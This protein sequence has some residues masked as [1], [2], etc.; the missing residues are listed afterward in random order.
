VGGEEVLV[1]YDIRPVTVPERLGTPEAVEFEASAA[2]GIQL[3]RA[4]WGHGDF[5]D[6]ATQMLARR[7]NDTHRGYA[8]FGAWEGETM[9]GRASLGWEREADASTVELTLGVLPSHRRR[10][11]G[12]RLLAAAE[13]AARDHGKSTSVAYSD[14]PDAGSRSDEGPSLHAPD[15]DAELP[16]SV[17][18]ARFAEAHGYVLAQIERVSSLRLDGR[19]DELRRELEER[20]ARASGA[21]YRL[22]LWTAHAPADLVDA[23]AAAKERMAIDVPAGGVTIDQERWDAARVRE[24]ESASLDGGLNLLV[25]AAVTTSGAVAGYT[26]LQLPLA[27][28]FAYQYDTL[29]VG[30]H[31]GHGLGMLVKL[32][33]LVELA[34]VAPERAVVY[35]WNADE[36][37]HMLAIN[38]ALGFRRCGLE[39][40]WQ[41]ELPATIDA[42]D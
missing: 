38:I 4:N 34:E 31:R 25:A 17:P 21:G 26:E 3:E 36:N 16:A 33:N 9:I 29:V 23:Y 15:G 20:T 10:G 18:A 5:A 7:Q 11:V 19:I 42:H 14:H 37:D 30:A 40:A 8:L 6:T 41:R 39:A 13:Q 32:A 28:E 12:S 35:T 27:R 2:V 24:Y 1:E 22:A